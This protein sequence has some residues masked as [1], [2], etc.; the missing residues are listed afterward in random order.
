MSTRFGQILKHAIMTCHP[1][2][3]ASF[4]KNFNDLKILLD[5]MTLSDINL[6]AHL[7]SNNIFKEPNKAPCTFVN[8]F[9]NENVV[10]V[11]KPGVV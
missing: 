8:I 10:R 9:E 4:K 5:S 3:A 2:N 6:P 7:Y 1:N 11:S